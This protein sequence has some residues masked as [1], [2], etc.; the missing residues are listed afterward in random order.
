M[1]EQKITE[2]KVDGRKNHQIVKNMKEE[3]SAG[4]KRG[5]REGN[6]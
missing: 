5:K 3:E 4:K 6:G 1:Q 2:R